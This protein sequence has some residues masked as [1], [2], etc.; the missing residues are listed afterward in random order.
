M[1]SKSAGQLYHRVAFDERQLISDGEGNVEG[2]FAQ[3]FECR[4]GY[5]FLRGGEAVIAARL[6]G[7]QPIVVR[8]RSSSETR[9]IR[10]NWRMRDLNDGSW[11]DSGETVWSGPIYAVRSIAATPDRMWLDV[12]VEAG[13]AA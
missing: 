13:V 3:V 11:Q 6:E 5:T 10:P 7:R 9:L 4:A 2:E 8:V 12:M 1:A